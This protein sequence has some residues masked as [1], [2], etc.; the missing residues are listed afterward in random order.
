MAGI[1]RR[2]WLA[3]AALFYCRDLTA[4][5]CQYTSNNPLS[6]I[7]SLTSLIP[8]LIDDT[9]EGQYG[10]VILAFIAFFGQQKL[11]GRYM[12]KLLS[13]VIICRNE[14]HIIGRTIAAAQQVSDDVV[15]VDSGSTDGTQSIITAPAQH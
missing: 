8:F 12:N 1:W 3:G 5:I 10:V 11:T 13:V 4:F 15:V 9:L 2:K 6:L 7:L 14:A